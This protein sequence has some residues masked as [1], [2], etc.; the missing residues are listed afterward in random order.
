M[1]VSE[2]YIAGVELKEL[3]ICIIAIK[4]K[5]KSY[6]DS[7]NL[8]LILCCLAHSKKQKLRNNSFSLYQ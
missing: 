6:I 7:M 5:S 1:Y 8:W 3:Q 4:Y 2:K